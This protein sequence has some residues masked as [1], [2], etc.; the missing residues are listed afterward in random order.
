M[1]TYTAYTERERKRERR[2]SKLA[3]SDISFKEEQ[4]GVLKSEIISH[5]STKKK[6]IS[7][8]YRTV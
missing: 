4:K 2:E 1:I 3:E 6:E 8:I 5:T 7:K